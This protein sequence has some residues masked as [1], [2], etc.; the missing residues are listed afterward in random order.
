MSTLV[1]G[2]LHSNLGQCLTSPGSLR[3]ESLCR[4][5]PPGPPSSPRPGQTGS[6]GGVRGLM[7]G[8][9]VQTEFPSWAQ[10]P[11]V[12]WPP[13]QTQWLEAGSPRCQQ[14]AVR[15]DHLLTVPSRGL[16]SVRASLV[17]LPLP[18]RAPVTPLWP[19]S[20]PL[21]R[22][23]PRLQMQSLWGLGLQLM[24]VGG[25]SSV[26]DRWEN[27]GYLG[28]LHSDARMGPWTWS[29]GTVGPQRSLGLWGK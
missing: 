19:H 24:N 5:G 4:E 12:P 13:R 28:P 6:G 8:P 14:V 21:P 1:L 29:L 2:L 11:A 3:G 9:E 20:L 15:R 10:L 26:H 7:P 27:A 25:H 18:A 23:R 22:Q 16:S 17:P